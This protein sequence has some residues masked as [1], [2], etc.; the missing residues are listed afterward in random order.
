M[1]EIHPGDAH[2]TEGLSLPQVILQ[3]PGSLQLLL[4]APEC[5]CVVAQ[6][7]VDGSEVAV[8]SALPGGVSK[9]LQDGEL[10]KCYKML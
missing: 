6:G 1:T 3:F 5:E 8:S 4:E 9:V 10:L 7:H 2:V